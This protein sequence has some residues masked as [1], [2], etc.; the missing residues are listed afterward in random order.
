MIRTRTRIAALAALAAVA[1]VPY[2][3]V[4]DA[5]T[6]AYFPESSTIDT[7]AYTL[8]VA[9]DDRFAT[10]GTLARVAAINA[11]TQ[12]GYPFEEPDRNEPAK[13][14]GFAACP[15]TVAI[16]AGDTVADALAASPAK[17]KTA[18]TVGTTTLD[19]TNAVLLVTQSARQGGNDLSPEV[20]ATL[21][22][23]RAANCTFDAVIFG[24]PVSVS[25]NAQTTLDSIATNVVRIDGATRF[26]T[27]ARI[28]TAVATGG[29]PAVTVHE[30]AATS[31]EKTGAV[32]LAEAF[33]GADALAAGPFAAAKNVPVLLAAGAELQTE[34]RNALL[35]LQP[36]TLL[37]LGGEE[38]LQP[39]VVDA[40]AEAAGGAEVIRIGGGNRY[41]TSVLVAQQLFGI[42]ESAAEDDHSNLAIGF[43]RSEGA[44]PD[45][46]GFPD[47]LAAAYFLDTFNDR[48]TAP[49][50][51]APAVEQNHATEDADGNEVYTTIGGVDAPAPAPLL[52][53]AQEEVP[54]EVAD[55]VTSLWPDDAAIKTADTPDGAN[56]GGFGFLFGGEAAIA[57]A[58]E[59]TLAA[60]LSG[61]TYD[62]ATATDV[63]ELALDPEKVFYTSANLAASATEAAGG[64]DADGAT[65]AGDKICVTRG[66]LVGGRWLTLY[67]D[68]ASR[69]AVLLG[70]QTVDYEE[71]DDGAYT[72][73]VSRF[74]CIAAT[75]MTAADVLGLSLSGHA[76]TP[77]AFD[78]GSAASLLR[79]LSPGQD[80]SV[81]TATGDPTAEVSLLARSAKST[82]VY[83]GEMTVTVAGTTFTDTPF[84]LSIEFTRTD[85]GRTTAIPNGG[86]DSL[87]F[88]ALF[89]FTGADGPNVT[90]DSIAG[91][92][93]TTASPLRLVGM[94]TSGDNRGAFVA[95]VSGSGTSFN[96]RDLV[97]D[98]HI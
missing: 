42:F 77:E 73:G 50:R 84:R 92:S 94:Y 70:A 27:A 62:A 60:A 97:L 59:A 43:A 41:E 4:A 80:L 61:G 90:F 91:E 18:L 67:D 93:S 34:T 7:T 17:D 85:T 5:T 48:A 29:L 12:G 23:L 19:M 57:D 39:A 74:Q 3:A 13:A 21:Q 96:L 44:G 33:T 47:A 38:A 54:A 64:V 32:I 45:H 68:S 35:E 75:G 16:A 8:R 46:K 72:S 49:K 14:Y 31:A 87:T 6:P 36:D 71:S 88:T 25:T 86:P 20:V 69:D 55:Y 2:G 56:D 95:T 82:Q 63:A 79:T 22:D 40:A 81:N 83:T 26:A 37:V 11:G 10:A 24:G 65:A 53:T 89:E 9:G 52:L 66:G 15:K 76:T 30:D 1:L 28:A 78:W 51:L 58:A 98:G